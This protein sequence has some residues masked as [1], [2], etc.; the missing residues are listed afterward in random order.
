MHWT[1]RPFN[2]TASCAMRKLHL[3]SPPRWRTTP[4]NQNASSENTRIA[5]STTPAPAGTSR[6]TT[7][8]SS[9]VAGEKIKVVDDKS[10]EDLT[11]SV[12]LQII[13]EQEQFGAAG[14]WR[15][16]ARDDHPLLWRPDAGHAQPLPRAG[17]HRDAAAAGGDAVAKWPRRCRRRSRRDRACAQE[18]GDVGTDAVRDARGL[19]R[20][21]APRPRAGPGPDE[22]TKPRTKKGK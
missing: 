6:W 5:G 11:R 14:A 17:V 8:A 7:C 9:I 4:C 21:S 20:P 12:L 22:T 18:H 16:A 10:G 13:S 3:A 2:K 19:R 1:R 15:R